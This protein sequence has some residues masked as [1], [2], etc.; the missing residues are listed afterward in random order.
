MVL[1]PTQIL[2]PNGILIG[3][4]VFAQLTADSPNTLQWV[5]AHFPLNCPSHGRSGPHLTHDSLGQSK[6]TNQTASRSVQP[7]CAAHRRVSLYFTLGHPFTPS[8]LALPMGD[9]DPHLIHGSLGRPKSSTQMASR[10]V[11]LLLQGSLV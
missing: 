4:A 11:Q 1:G 8:K 7:F 5:P 3:L 9:P 2:N 6:P 10:S